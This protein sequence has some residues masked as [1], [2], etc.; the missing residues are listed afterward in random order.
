MAT[1]NSINKTSG[2]ITV[3][4]TANINTTGSAVSSIGT[5][6]TG[7]TNIGNATGN[8]S[9]TGSLGTTTTLTAGTGL[10]LTSGNFVVPD[11]GA[12]SDTGAV[13]FL[14]GSTGL[15]RN[16]GYRNIFVGVDAGNATLTTGSGGGANNTAC[17]VSS[18]RALTTGQYNGA[19]G[20]YALKSCT[21]GSFNYA[22]GEGAMELL[23]TGQQN[24]AMGDYALHA[25]TTG[26]YNTAV[27]E[28]TAS[29]YTGAE[30]S[31]VT[32]RNTGTVGESNV[33]RIG[34]Q[35]SG[36]LQQNK[37]YIA[38]I[39]NTAVGATSNVT[40]V[41]SSGQLGGL[42]GS[43]NTVLMGGT[44]PSFTGSPSISGSLTAGTGITVTAG[45]LVFT[46]TGTNGITSVDTFGRTVGI[47][48]IPA[49]I[50]NT[51]LFGTVASSKRFKHDIVDMN[52][53]SDV[54]MKL[55]PVMFTYNSNKDGERS[56][57]LI[58]EEVADI[59]PDLVAYDN[60]KA[61]YTVKYHE[62]PAMLLNEIQKLRKRIEVLEGAR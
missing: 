31:N 55:R 43:A 20:Y 35:G 15:L 8:T 22:F 51:G 62:L 26:S 7:A 49:L 57:G 14:S 24:V 50:D 47:S 5:G 52:D 33:I 29:A 37:C 16:R 53:S 27:G 19:F 44:A 39:Y 23:T 30:S 32:I 9:V 45:G 56:P 13:N 61:P 21:T 40:L 11:S 34:T 41:D 25:I 42:A 60:E 3:T 48:G 59:M 2:G 6:G 1:Q 10:T 58:A 12:T 46:T 38:G 17:G 36:N 54:L 18:L 28:N 4:G